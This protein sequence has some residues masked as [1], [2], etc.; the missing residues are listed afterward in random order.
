MKAGIVYADLVNTVSPTYA[1]EIQTKEYGY[2]L[3]GLLRSRAAKL[4]GILNGIDYDVWNPA[5]DPLLPQ[6]YSKSSLEKKGK[7]K[8]GLQKV[9]G[10]PVE[11]KVPLIGI[12][13]RVTEQKG[14]DILI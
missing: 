6:K 9:C 7:N 8:A 2:G 4:S 3:D 14:F 11:G 1:R 13:S 10:L 12:V 5:R